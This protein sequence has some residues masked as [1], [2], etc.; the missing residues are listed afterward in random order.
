MTPIWSIRP[1]LA[2]LRRHSRQ[3]LLSTS[4][5][6]SSNSLVAPPRSRPLPLPPSALFPISQPSHQATSTDPMPN[7][8]AYKYNFTGTPSYPPALVV[9]PNAN[10]TSTLYFS[11]NGATGITSY[12]ISAGARAAI[13]A[14]IATVNTTGFETSFLLDGSI[15]AT[16]VHVTALR[17][18]QE[19]PGGSSAIV[20]VPV[21]G[22][23][24]GTNATTVGTAASS[25]ATA[26]ST[27]A[28]YKGAAAGLVVPGIGSIFVLI[29]AAVLGI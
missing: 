9:L 6:P 10:G 13:I 24:S 7:S 18:A 16:Y 12:I 11:W 5:H 15:N 26:A 28:P 22:A 25:T 4:D 27:V 2:L 20:K 21:S 8:R 3:S 29:I 14:P 23:G 1:N 19:V 17:G